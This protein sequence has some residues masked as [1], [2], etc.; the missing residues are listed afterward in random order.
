MSCKISGFLNFH[1]SHLKYEKF[2]LCLQNTLNTLKMTRLYFGV[3]HYRGSN[4]NNNSGNKE[5]R[6]Q[7][8][9]DKVELL[10][11]KNRCCFHWKNKRLLNIHEQKFADIA[12]F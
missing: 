11:L 12:A 8:I 4:N 6:D 10:P 3:L 5:I 1:V 9:R 7:K 2:K